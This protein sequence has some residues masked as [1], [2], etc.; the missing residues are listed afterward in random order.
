MVVEE[1]VETNALK[2]NFP[3]M[4]LVAEAAGI[5]LTMT[6]IQQFEEHNACSPER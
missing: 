2:T 5:A 4:L 6:R 1:I 3:K